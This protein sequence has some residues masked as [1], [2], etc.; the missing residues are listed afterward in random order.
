[1]LFLDELTEFKRDVLEFLRQ[2]LEDGYVT[3]TRT[4]QSVVFPAQF[5]LVASTNPCPC[6]FYGDSVQP[7]TCTPRSRENYWS[8]LSG[9]LMDGSD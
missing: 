6:G 8:R 4:R 1:V 5:T 3:I 9:P 2:P 7:C